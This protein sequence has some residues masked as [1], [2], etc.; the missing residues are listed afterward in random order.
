LRLM[1]R[2]DLRLGGG[3]GLSIGGRF[4]F[5]LQCGPA[6][7]VVGA[8][9]VVCGGQTALRPA[10][11]MIEAAMVR[12]RLARYR[13]LCLRRLGRRRRS[14]H[15][16]RPATLSLALTLPLA[17]TQPLT[18]TLALALAWPLRWRRR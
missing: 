3:R 6:L 13:S 16:G 7:G 11:R 2:G 8:R 15:A 10:R 9:R 4:G 5:R 12:R 14:E 18:L 17:L 1:L